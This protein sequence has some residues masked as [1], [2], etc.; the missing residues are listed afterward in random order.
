M[1]TCLFFIDKNAISTKPDKRRRYSST[2]HAVFGVF[3]VLDFGALFWGYFCRFLF[4]VES[5]SF[6]SLFF[7]RV[8]C[9][10]PGPLRLRQGRESLIRLLG[11]RQSPQSQFCSW[12]ASPLAECVLLLR[13]SGA[14]LLV[15]LDGWL[16]GVSSGWILIISVTSSSLASAGAVARLLLLGWFERWC[17][18]SGEQVGSL[19]R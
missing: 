16:V 3:A 17:T 1:T 10:E 11:L 14:G 12:L 15:W 4:K 5:R 19:N 7:F 8:A 2:V 6:P 18:A 13:F 9:A